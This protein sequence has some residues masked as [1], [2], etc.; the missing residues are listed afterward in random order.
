MKERTKPLTDEELTVLSK[1]TEAGLRNA[2]ADYTALTIVTKLIRDHVAD[3]VEIERLQ[4]ALPII[5]ERERQDAKW[6]PQDH[7]LAMWVT[8]LMEEVG[9]LAAAALCHRFGN[10]DHPELDW[11]KEAIQVAAVALSM[12]EQHKAAEAGE[13]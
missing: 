9:E 4:R 13:E 10:D 1:G 3:K 7:E 6:G 2:I 5:E 11:R 8:I 12:T